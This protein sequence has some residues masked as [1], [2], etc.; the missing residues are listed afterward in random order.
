MIGLLKRLFGPKVDMGALIAA[1]ATII[2]VRTPAEYA[3]GHI[4]GS[5]NIPLNTLGSKV[6][7]LD[8]SSTIITCCATGMRSAAARAMLRS[9]GFTD[10]YNAG[11]WF[12]L[13]KYEQ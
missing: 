7:E 11:P 10:V 9:G 5:K 3:G 2:D 12:T 4:K 8:K 6:N 1:G 13:R